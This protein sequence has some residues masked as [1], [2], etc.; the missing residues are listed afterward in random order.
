[1]EA[2]YDVAVIGAGPGGFSCAGRTAAEGLK[3]ICFDPLVNPDDGEPALGGTCANVGCIP[4]KALLSASL[5]Y[6]RAKEGSKAF[7]LAGTEL[8]VDFAAVHAHRAKA[9]KDSNRGLTSM[10]KSSGI[11][12]V[13][14]A[15][16]F[17]GRGERGWVLET[18]S[19]Q[20]VE[21][22]QV[23]VAC[24]TTPRTLPGVSFDEEVICSNTGAL[25]WQAPPKR[26]GIIGAGV[27]GLEL[28]SVWTRYGSETTVFDL[29]PAVLPFAGPAI[30]QAALKTLTGQGIK[31]ELGVRI[32]SVARTEE[33]V[34]VTFE[35]DGFQTTHT[36][37][38][39][40]VAVGR[41]STVASVS[42]QAVGLAVNE[43]GFVQ[44]DDEC[45]TNLP[46]V[47]AVG[48]IVRGPQ[49]A[50]K[51]IDEGAAVADRICGKVRPPYLSP[52]PS[53]VYTHP[54]FAWVGLTKEAAEAEGRTVVTGRAPFARN[55]L[56]RT[57]DET[58]GFIDV[59]CDAKTGR[60]LGAQIAGAA[61]GELVSLFAQA[62]A[63]GATHED[64]ALVIWPHPSMAESIAGAASA[65]MAAARRAA[66]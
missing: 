15:V 53:V 28:G 47:W 62:I 37:E 33:G 39:L 4:S 57:T 65:A 36:F 3:T 55:P 16:H 18:G 44:V 64:L 14:E 32:V 29:A 23:V 58:D 31:F 24:G 12:V 38:K 60:V 48:D 17:K 30:P 2:F 25:A 21:A 42:P 26:L 6:V 11:T 61:A 59:V 50:H 27:I 54:E 52:V 49:L 43:R 34:T 63:Y 40:L 19:G 20:T 46:G 7:G 45:R 1:M 10:F 41:Q 66:A 5:A 9:I 8:V 35:R 56:A 51:A 22:G 13:Y